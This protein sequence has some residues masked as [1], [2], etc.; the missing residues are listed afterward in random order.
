[1]RLQLGGDRC[2]GVGL[3][4]AIQRS[5]IDVRAIVSGRQSG[6]AGILTGVD[7]DHDRQVERAG[8]IEVTL[9]VGRHGHDRSGA[10]IG[11]DVIGGPDRKSFTVDRVD[12]IPVEE[13]AGFRPGGIEAIHLGRL[14]H[15]LEVLGEFLLSCRTRCEF[16]RE[17]GIGCDDEE[18]RAVQGVRSRC[19][20][21]YWVIAPLDREVDL[22][23]S[24]LPDPIALHEQHLLR[25]CPLQ[26][27]H[28]IEETLGIVGD[29]Q[30]PLGELLL[31]D[32]GIAALT[33][34]FDHLLIRQHRLAFRAPIDAA[35]SPIGKTA[36]VHL[37]EEPLIPSVVRRVA[38]VEHAI[39]V[40]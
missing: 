4:Q 28:V 3:H 37:Q 9:V 13:D 15:L 24:R 19:V 6:D 26:L 39:P 25:P 14:L 12:R 29:P 5:G 16:C 1:M 30:I 27:L 34:T 17:V 2:D 40:E 31:G 10:I 36:F 20:H 21:R 23:T 22:R 38:C 33:C 7:D 35:R 8:E 18:G 32:L 11:Q